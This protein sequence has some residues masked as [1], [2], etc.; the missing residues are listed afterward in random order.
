[1]RTA[2]PASPGVGRLATAGT[3]WTSRRGSA[4]AAPTASP[5]T[6]WARSEP[7]ERTRTTPPSTAG[8]RPSGSR[9]RWTWHGARK[10]A[11]RPRCAVGS[12][13]GTG[14]AR[15]GRGPS[16][17]PWSLRATG[18][19]PLRRDCRLRFPPPR[20]PPLRLRHH[21]RPE[22]WSSQTPR[23]PPVAMSA[24]TPW[25]QATPLGRHGRTSYTS[26][27][28]SS[29]TMSTWSHL[30]SQAPSLSRPRRRSARTP[31][32]GAP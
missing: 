18:A 30:A 28:G 14:P 31:P 29:A 22:S 11:L 21:C 27:S 26:C 2:R 25:G 1:M 15:S 4:P 7:A 3:E 6:S 24:S 32:P 17:T 20:R 19:G 5:G 8:A 9:G 23:S 12:S 10:R 16:D 13:T